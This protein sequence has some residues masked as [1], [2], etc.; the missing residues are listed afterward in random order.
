MLAS[1]SPK[2]A[3]AALRAIRLL[4]LFSADRPQLQLAEVSKLAGLNKTTAHRLLGALCSEEMLARDAKTGGYQLGAGIMALG[5]QALSANDL[6]LRARRYLQ[7][8][9]EETG[10]TATLE[11]PIESSMLII[12]EFSGKHFVAASGNVGT[13]WAMHATSTGKAILAFDEHAIQRLD[14]S[15]PKLTP[16]TVTAMKTLREQFPAI[17]QRGYAETVDELEAGFSGVGTVVMDGSGSVI[18]ALSVCG[19]SS[20]MLENRRAELGRRLCVAARALA[21][22]I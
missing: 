8:L 9:A 14:A 4:K 7:E 11:V 6:R 10:E 21:A 5:S 2:G 12:D 16:R 15:L 3:Q 13:R 18:G 1:T 22:R 19:P 20:R 17:R